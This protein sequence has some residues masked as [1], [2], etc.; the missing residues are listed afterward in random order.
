MICLAIK[1]Y[2]VKKKHAFYTTY[3]S[4]GEQLIHAV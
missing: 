2:L 1:Y 3:S 4:K